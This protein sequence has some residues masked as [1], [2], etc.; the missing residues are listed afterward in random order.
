M[1]QYRLCDC[2]IENIVFILKYAAMLVNLL[3]LP[4]WKWYT[5]QLEYPMVISLFILNFNFNL[6]KLKILFSSKSLFPV[7]MSVYPQSSSWWTWQAA[8]LAALWKNVWKCDQSISSFGDKTWWSSH[9][10]TACTTCC[11]VNYE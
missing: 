7:I 10:K 5:E 6:G 4:C 9:I 1:S 2:N 11:F 3:L 8:F